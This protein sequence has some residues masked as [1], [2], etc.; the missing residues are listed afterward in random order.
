MP[1]DSRVPVFFAASLFLFLLSM[2]VNSRLAPFSLYLILIGPMLIMPALSLKSPALILY[3]FITGISIDALLPQPYWLFIYG[4]PAISLLIRS[5]RSHFRTETS[6]RYV[7]LAHIANFSCI[8]LLTISQGIYL[9]QFS[10][11][12]LQ[13]LAIILLSHTILSIVAPW[14]FSFERLLFQILNIEHAQEDD[15]SVL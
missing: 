7:L 3:S 5:M 2:M 8:G 10:V 15:F 11:S 13:I 4:L 12:L 6:Y 1:F 14:F 9:G